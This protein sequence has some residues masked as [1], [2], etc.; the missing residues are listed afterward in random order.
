MADNARIQVPVPTIFNSDPTEQIFARGVVDRQNDMSG[1]SYMFLNA[2]QQRRGEDQDAYMSG[3]REANRIA[4]A[5]AQ[6]ETMSNQALEVLKQ[7]VKMS[8]EI[9]TPNTIMPI[10]KMLIPD[11]TDPGAAAKLALLQ[12]QAN[13]NNAKAAASAQAGEPEMQLNTSVSPSGV[14]IQEGKV[15]FKRAAD[16]VK[17]AGMLNDI[18]RE[19]LRQRG[20]KGSGPGGSGLPNAN[21][22]DVS[23]TQEYLK[24]RWGQ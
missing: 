21:P 12:S 19:L 7:A 1:L 13:E 23:K 16:A 10:M 22:V 18:E 4:A 6:Q 20:I 15:K 14:S 11:G 5:L 8:T 17:A 3:V 9:G 2:A 24:G